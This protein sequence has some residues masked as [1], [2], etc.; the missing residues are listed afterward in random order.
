MDYPSLSPDGRTIAFI[1]PV[2]GYDQVFVMLTSGGDPLQLTKDEGNKT[3]LNFSS[4]GTEIYFSQTLGDPDIW[5][6]PTLGGSPKHLATGRAVVPSADGQSLFLQK[7][8]GRIVRTPKSGSSEELLYTL[9]S[10]GVLFGADLKAYPDGKNLLISTTTDS[11]AVVFRRL[12]LS[13]HQLTNLAEL[14]SAS[15]FTSWATPGQKP[16]RHPQ[17]Q[18]HLQSVGILPCRS[19]PQ[20]DHFRPRSRSRPHVRSQRQGRLFY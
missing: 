1:S 16:L 5:S 18:R 11:G 7:T 12:D 17:D 9:P 15:P 10:T 4:D 3:I 13:A 2:E 20:A 8:D 14:T 19:I 6:I